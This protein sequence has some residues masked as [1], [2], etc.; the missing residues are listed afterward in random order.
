MT[1]TTTTDA[2][3]QRHRL[4]GGVLGQLGVTGLSV[5]QQILFV[6]LFVKMW[7]ADQYASWLILFSLS[8]LIAIADFGLHP[9]SINKYQAS[10]A[11]PGRRAQ[12]ALSRDVREIINAYVMNAVL[13]AVAFGLVIL[14]I[15]PVTKLG[16]KGA[17]P[18]AL[19]GA[20]VLSVGSGIVVNFTSGCSAVYR[21]HL[22]LARVMIARLLIQIAQIIGQAWIL[23]SQSSIFA[24]ALMFFIINVAAVCYMCAIDIPHFARIRPGAWWKFSWQKQAR[25]MGS[26]LPFV[27]PSAADSIFNQ[28]PVF[29]LG[30]VGASPL[31]IIIFNLSRVVAAVPRMLVQQLCGLLGPEIGATYVRDEKGG[32]RANLQIALTMSAVIIGV[33][34]GAMVGLIRPLYEF[35]TLKAVPFDAVTLGLMLGALVLSSHTFAAVAALLYCNQPGLVT[36]LQL[37][38]IGTSCVLVAVLGRMW[39]APGAAGGLFISEAIASAGPFAWALVERFSMQWRDMLL[40]SVVPALL[41]LVVFAALSFALSYAVDV[42]STAGLAAATLIVACAAATAGYREFHRVQAAFGG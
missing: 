14:L 13:I 15:D 6:P 5:A 38:R 24:M 17:T 28:G 40:W 42:H 25:T 35:W 26:A 33:S 12:A 37:V 18:L 20:V 23:L 29:I 19:S 3:S 41:W 9:L 36:K 10:L 22:E 1:E 27:I 7:D 11:L 8:A 2:L 30:L 21:A 39:G 32:V 34:S 4:L 16:L 31:S